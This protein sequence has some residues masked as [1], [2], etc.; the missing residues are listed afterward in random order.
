MKKLLKLLPLLLLAVCCTVLTACD[1]NDDKYVDAS[2]LPTEAKGFVSEYFPG[3]TIITVEKDHNEYE[4]RLS[5]GT[6]IDFTRSGEWKDVDAP[7][8]KAI[9]S[10]FYP[11]AIDAYIAANMNGMGINEISKE[12]RGYDVELLNGLELIFSTDGT[13][14]ATDH[15]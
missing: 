11:A 12:R 3:E 8:G 13:F 1:G 9:P 4:V 6:K 15:D 2:E 14:I 10:G 7:T 5:D